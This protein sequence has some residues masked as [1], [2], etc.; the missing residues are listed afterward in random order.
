MKNHI[1]L[2]GTFAVVLMLLMITLSVSAS[3][4]ITVHK[5]TIN[6]TVDGERVA[7][8]NFLYEG[9]TY[10]PLRRIAEMFGKNVEWVEADNAA[11]ITDAESVNITD[12][13]VSDG[14]GE[15]FITIPVERNTMNIYLEDQKV[16]ADNF[17][18]EGRT[19]VPLRKISEMFG[20]PVDWEQYTATASIGTKSISIF[21]GDVVGTVNG[22]PYTEYIYEYYNNFFEAELEYFEVY[23]ESEYDFANKTLKEIIAEHITQDYA[24]IDYAFKNGITMRGQ[25][26][27][28][29]FDA[30]NST[31]ESNKGSEEALERVLFVEGYPSRQAYFYALYY[32]DLYNQLVALEMPGI[33]DDIVEV[34]YD[35]R[36]QSG[37]VDPNMYTYDHAR[38]ELAVDKVE[39]KMTPVIDAAFHEFK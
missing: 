21:D 22:I 29:Y 16:D 3:E 8:D 18:Y 9:T 30:I 35:D 37:M 7:A 23:G 13:A 2:Y 24:V 12:S 6:I 19:Y 26:H 10:V 28:A 5:N 20:K 11:V 32:N 17:L 4:N 14:K 38:Y 31:L 39:E 36:I 1:K 25:Y 34:H 33:D 15:K 27:K